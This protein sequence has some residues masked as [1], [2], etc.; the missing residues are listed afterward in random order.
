MN[1]LSLD[2]RL[3][4]DLAASWTLQKRSVEANMRILQ[5]PATSTDSST[6]NSMEQLKSAVE[7]HAGPELGRCSEP[8]R[9]TEQT[10]NSR[11]FAASCGIAS[12][13]TSCTQV[14]ARPHSA[15]SEAG[16]QGTRGGVFK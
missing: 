9:A 4:F 3:R 8:S 10:S 15:I 11:G 12:K 7:E 6:F 1:S 2:N 14:G 16:L 5:Q 13:A